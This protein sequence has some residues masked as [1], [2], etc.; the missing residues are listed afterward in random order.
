MSKNVFLLS[1]YVTHC[2]WKLF[3]L[4][5]LLCSEISWYA[6]PWS[7]AFGSWRALSRD[8]C[9]ELS[10]IHFNSFFP[11]VSVSFCFLS[12]KLLLERWPFLFKPPM[13]RSLSL[14]SW[15]DQCPHINSLPG[16]CL[17][18]V[19]PSVRVLKETR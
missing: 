5:F 9:S 16:S 2:L 12:M 15:T 1:L 7:I 19:S 14:I 18:S 11:V 4:L 17:A 13:S 6:V 8:S 3:R 10:D